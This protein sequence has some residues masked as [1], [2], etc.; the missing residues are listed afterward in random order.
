MAAV[1]HIQLKTRAAPF[2]L[3]LRAFHADYNKFS[4]SNSSYFKTHHTRSFDDTPL[5]LDVSMSSNKEQHKSILR[6]Q[7]R[8]VW[9][10][11]GGGEIPEN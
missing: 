7:Q 2:F 4:Q 10:E 8:K 6:G 5:G 3:R 9:G 1:H 11:G